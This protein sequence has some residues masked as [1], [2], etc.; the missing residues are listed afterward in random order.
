[1][2]I[3]LPLAVIASRRDLW[4]DEAMLLH[5]VNDQSLVGPATPLGHYEQALPYGTYLLFKGLTA[6]FGFSQFVLQLPSIVAWLVALVLMYRAAMHSVRPWAAMLGAVVALAGSEQVFQ[7]TS[8]KHYAIELAACAVVVLAAKRWLANPDRT[9]RWTLPA[10]AVATLP[11][12]NTSVVVTCGVFLSLALVTL[13]Q[14]LDKVVRRTRL[15]RL[16]SGAAVFLVVFGIWFGAVVRP[17]TSFQLANVAYDTA[18]WK[19]LVSSVV[20]LGSPT[21]S[22]VLMLATWAVLAAVVVAT[23]FRALKRWNLSGSRLSPLGSEAAR[24]FDVVLLVVVLAACL[25]GQITGAV[26]FLSPRSVLFVAATMAA[27][28]GIAADVVASAVVVRWRGA[29]RLVTAVAAFAIALVGADVVTHVSVHR[30]QQ[31]GEVLAE[32]PTSCE[33]V[34]PYVYAQPAAELY[35]SRMPAET[36]LVGLVSDASGKGESN[37]DRRELSNLDAYAREYA[38][39]VNTYDRP[40]LLFAHMRSGDEAVLLAA[41]RAEGYSCANVVEHTGAWLVACERGK[42]AS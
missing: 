22:A 4:L 18:T 1:M 7:A 21:G 6:T 20:Q 34:A 17:S 33:A 14:D 36:P 32:A 2:A 12:A 24:V 35:V 13:W 27:P 3:A 26:N 25:A 5:A 42:V 31:V 41:V 40:C 28:L 10:I 15:L 19:S 8:F 16:G 38:Q 29:Q 11:F 9:K 30:V 39:A 37:W 23:V